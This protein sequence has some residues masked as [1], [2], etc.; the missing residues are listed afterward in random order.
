MRKHTRF[1]TVFVEANTQ[2]LYSVTGL[3]TPV[4]DEMV[5][6][7]STLKITNHSEA[8]AANAPWPQA[9]IAAVASLASLTTVLFV[10]VGFLTLRAYRR[11]KLRQDEAG[12]DLVQPLRASSGQ[13][14]YKGIN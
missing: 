6:F 8:V 2:I 13:G 10:S 7:I 1:V 5:K 11:R 9:A 12:I 14:V 3:G 4:F